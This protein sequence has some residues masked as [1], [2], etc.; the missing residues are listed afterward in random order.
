MKSV[1]INGHAGLLLQMWPSLTGTAYAIVHSA[2]MRKC[3]VGKVGSHAYGIYRV[4]ALSMLELADALMEHNGNLSPDKKHTCQGRK[5]L[6][7]RLKSHVADLPT[8]VTSA[9]GSQS[10]YLPVHSEA[11]VAPGSAADLPPGQGTQML[12]TLPPAP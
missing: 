6:H 9:S 8:S 3:G 5:R 4:D 1:L 7:T 11:S 2:P 12:L 10:L